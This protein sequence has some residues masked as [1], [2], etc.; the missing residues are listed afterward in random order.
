MKKL[1]ARHF[2][3]IRHR[4]TG[5]S[6]RESARMAGYAPTAVK[7]AAVRLER[8]PLVVAELAKTQ[9]AIR[10]T[11]KYDAERAMA[12]LDEGME[13]SRTTDNA[14]AFMRA[15]ELRSK[16]N[17]LLIERVDQRNVGGFQIHI[18]GIDEPA[19]AAPVDVTPE[20]DPFS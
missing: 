14:T 11:T 12:E 15:V 3:Y 4:S 10:E 19:P 6:A 7:S 16:I 8:H 2:E 1:S 18:S 5:K 17:G 20:V 9:V 13:L